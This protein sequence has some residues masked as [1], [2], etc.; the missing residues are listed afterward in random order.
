[1]TSSTDGTDK[2][3]AMLQMLRMA[4]PAFTDETD[5]NSESGIESSRVTRVEGAVKGTMRSRGSSVRGRGSS[6]EGNT[7]RNARKMWNILSTGMKQNVDKVEVF[8]VGG[9]LLLVC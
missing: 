7:K 4:S 8:L 6:E 9:L 1:M 3:S 2:D 5:Q